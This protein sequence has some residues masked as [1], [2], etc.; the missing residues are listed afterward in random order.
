ML[1]EEQTRQAFLNLLKRRPLPEHQRF[2]NLLLERSYADTPP[3]MSDEELR[4]FIE[5]VCS[6]QIFTSNHPKATPNIWQLIWMPLAF[7]CFADWPESAKRRIGVF[8]EHMGRAGRRAINGCPI[9]HSVR[10]MHV[11]DWRRAHRGILLELER[12]KQI[13]VPLE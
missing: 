7:G 11:A 6:G 1:P 12:R 5:G 2:L 10:T 4:E 9:F 8:W 13:E 3:R